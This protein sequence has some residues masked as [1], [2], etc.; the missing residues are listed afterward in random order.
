MRLR[1]RLLMAMALSLGLGFAAIEF[2]TYQLEVSEAEGSARTQAESVRAVLMATRRVYHRQF[3]ASGLPLND[4]TLGFLPAHALNRISKE[5]ANWDRSGFRFNNVSDRPRNPSQRADADELAAMGYFRSNPK[6]TSYFKAIAPSGV[7]PY[8]LYARPIWV[9]KYCLRCHGSPAQAP[10][11]I[12]S[13]YK[14]AFGYREGELRGVL[15]IKI[16][17]VYMGN[18]V[19]SHLLRSAPLHLA[20]FVLVFILA[21]RLFRRHLLVPLDALAAVVGKYDK[22][23]ALRAPPLRGELAALGESF[24]GMAE[25]IE[26]Q[27]HALAASEAKYRQVVEDSKDAIFM[28]AD[29]MIGEANAAMSTLLGY[30]E[31]ALIGLPLAVICPDAALRDELQHRMATEGFVRDFQGVMH[32]RSGEERSVLLSATR[33]RDGTPG[34]FHGSFRDI[35][36]QQRAETER[37]RLMTA[38]EQSED[39]VVITDAEGAIQYTNPAFA[40][41]TG[42]TRAEASTLDP[43]RLLCGE[44]EP[45]FFAELW[46]VLRAGEVW[47][48]RYSTTRRDGEPYQEQTTISPVRNAAGEIAHFVALKRDITREVALERQLRQAE[49]LGAV[50]QLAGGIAHD[51]NNIL[52]GILGNT[53]FVLEELVPGTSLHS[54]VVE[55]KKSANRAAA[56]TRQLLAFSRR[57][58]LHPVV[59][60][61]PELVAELLMMLRRTVGAHIKLETVVVGAPAAIKADPGSLEQVLT[62]LVLNS[63]DAISGQ[64][65]IVVKAEQVILGAGEALRLGGEAGAYVCLSVEDDGEGIEA[66]VCARIFEPFFSTKGHAGTGLGLSMV[67]GIVRQHSGLIAVTSVRGNGTAIRLYFPALD[68]AQAVV[69]RATATATERP[70]ERD[71]GRVVLVA[72]DERTVRQVAARWLRR[73]GYCVIEAEDGVEAVEKLEQHLATV[74]LMV[75]DV[76]MPRMGGREVWQRALH[77]KPELK[78]LF[79]SGYAEEGI[80]TEFVLDKGLSFLPKPYSGTELVER[81]QAL[82]AEDTPPSAPVG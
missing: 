66:A 53:A 25:R 77:L 40:R 1:T 27:H 8:Y 41:Q 23:P 67:D 26:Q 35:T 10:A 61:V 14:A 43:K 65:T 60:H 29:G 36:E 19:G 9:E 64:G 62:N 47:H 38:I 72:E 55:I 20:V 18:K 54:D 82:L 59:L 48:G 33:A 51:F 68:R 50:G 2:S 32:H 42:F 69:P 28:V 5:A 57:Q 6:R 34:S 17:K 81:L 3:I 44:Q 74:E 22:V 56:L 73:A 63:R 31:D 58:V 16:P 37:R 11:T 13:H 7:A 21:T 76:V 45:A 4:K 78:V 52:T 12:R 49:K 79:V 24:N 80:H 71:S 39:V 70:A 30:K 46:A 75:L 15:S